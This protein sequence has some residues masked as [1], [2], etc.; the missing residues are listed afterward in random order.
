MRMI[1]SGPC[2]PALG[3]CERVSEAGDAD[4]R[5]RVGVT[6]GEALVSHDPAGGV[7][8]VG[9]VV[10]TAARLES[11][12]PLGGVLV[13]GWTY[14]ATERAIRYEAAEAVEAKG[15]SEPVEAWVAVAPRSIVPE[16]VRVGGLPLVGR[17]ARGRPAARCA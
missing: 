8:A 16:Q 1:R 11:A 3:I 14:R 2:A 7:D 13:D 5:V 17:D 15:K 6:S 4:L 10:N 12:A 9:D